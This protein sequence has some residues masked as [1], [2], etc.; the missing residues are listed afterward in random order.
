MACLFCRQTSSVRALK[1][2]LE[3]C[4]KEKEHNCVV[5]CNIYLLMNTSRSYGASLAIWDHTVLPAT[6][7]RHECTR[8]ALTQARQA[9]TRF[10][11]PGGMEGWVGLGDLVKYEDCILANGRLSLIHILTGRG[12]VL[13]WRRLKNKQERPAVADKPARRLRKVCTVK[14]SGVVKLYSWLAYR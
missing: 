7:T 11:C 13:V 8:P 10:T 6:G 3:L 2:E 4:T 9:G 1:R 14:S 12:A 5:N